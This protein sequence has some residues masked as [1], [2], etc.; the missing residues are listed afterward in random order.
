MVTG[1]LASTR[2]L[3]PVLATVPEDLFRQ[4]TPGAD[5]LVIIEGGRRAML[6]LD[7][8]QMLPEPG[9]FPARLKVECG[10]TKD[11]LSERLELL[12]YRTTSYVESE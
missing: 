10:L 3:V 7:V 4:L 12:C 9:N 6:L 1:A 2:P 5:G 11:Y 8:W